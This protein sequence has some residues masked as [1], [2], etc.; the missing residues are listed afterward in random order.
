MI[1]PLPD[2]FIVS[3]ISGD[4]NWTYNNTTNTVTWTLTN[5]P[6]GD[7]YLYITGKVNKPGTYVFSSSI[8]SDNYNINTEGVT[9]ITINTANEVNATSSTRTI[10]MQE[11]G[12]PITALILAIL[13]VI[14]GLL[15]KKKIKTF[16]FFYFFEII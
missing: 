3:N 5:V 16:S 11:T 2:G 6:K 1:I 8:S 10:G 12:L 7:P 15:P 14:G 4:G 13:M 9:P